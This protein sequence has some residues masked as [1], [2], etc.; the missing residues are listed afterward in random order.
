MVDDAS[1]DIAR[2]SAVLSSCGAADVTL[3]PTDESGPRTH[4]D[5]VYAASVPL[6]LALPSTLPD[7]RT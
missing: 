4:A 6:T 5:A 2:W 3:A 1:S 7:E